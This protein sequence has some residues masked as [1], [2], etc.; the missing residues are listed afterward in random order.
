MAVL[1]DL[2]TGLRTLIALLLVA[3]IGQGRLDLAAVLLSIG[4]LS[5]FFDGKSA[6]AAD[7]PTHL[8]QWDIYAD[9]LV[10]V[11]ILLGL[12]FGGYWPSGLVL[13]LVIGMGGGWLV[14]HNNALSSAVQAIA[15]GAFMWLLFSQRV[16]S[17][18]L[19]PVTVLTIMTLNW[20]RFVHGSIPDFF[21]GIGDLARPRT[22][23]QHRET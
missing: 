20:H 13:L 16:D 3:V 22:W 9:T 19:P 8:K 1:A 12:A 5:D 2:L 6:R 23:F 15:Y 14:L 21:E 7:R 17:W 4:W 10:G 11:G 18:W